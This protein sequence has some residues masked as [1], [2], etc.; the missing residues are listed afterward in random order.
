MRG[1]IDFENA[2]VLTTN[3]L[4][5]FNDGVSVVSNGIDAPL[6]F[7]PQGNSCGYFNKSKLE[8][9]FFAN[10]YNYLPNLRITF[11][12][13]STDSREYYEVSFVSPKNVKIV[14]EYSDVPI[15]MIINNII[16]ISIN[17][18]LFHVFFSDHIQYNATNK[19]NKNNNII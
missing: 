3:G 11:D 14:R 2:D 8:L 15:F 18:K 5:V 17:H 10:N 1:C 13:F 19:D 7:C 16:Y 6:D 9:P 12:M 4:Y